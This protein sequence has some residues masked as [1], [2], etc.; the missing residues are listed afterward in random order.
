MQEFNDFLNKYLNTDVREYFQLKEE[1][2]EHISDVITNHY[3]RALEIEPKLIWMYLDK[4]QGTIEKSEEI[5]NY[6]IADIFKRTLD[7]INKDCSE[8]KYFPKED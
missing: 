3:K 1:D 2:K 5:E 4:I 7:K 8:Y 6:E